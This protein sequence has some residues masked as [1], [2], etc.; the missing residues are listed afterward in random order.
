M[1]KVF[2]DEQ[3]R[4][5]DKKLD[6]RFVSNRKGGGN[7]TLKYLQGHDAID[8]ADRIFGYGNWGYRPLSCEQQVLIDPMTGEAV[9]VA[10]KAQVELTVRGCVA[11]IVE[12]GSQPVAVWS[13]E[14]HI[15]KARIS[16]AKYNK[17]PVDESEF[18]PFEK[19]KARGVIVEAHEMAEKGAVTD[20]LKRA[21]R[22]F[23]EQF[24]N[25]LYGDGRVMLDDVETGTQHQPSTHAPQTPA[26]GVI[27]EQQI[28]SIR[29]LCQ[30]L[31]K[32]E[33]ENL[34]SLKYLVAKAMIQQLTTEHKEMRQN[35]LSPQVPQYL[36]KEAVEVLKAE[37]VEVRS[38]ASEKINE[39]WREFKAY[40]NENVA[41]HDTQITPA[42]KQKMQAYIDQRRPQ[43]QAS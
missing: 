6:P 36:S 23:G 39:L 8:Q 34:T 30:H 14:D 29:K 43:Q 33:P 2:S 13:V 31:S 37:W 32:D 15:I 28:A 42:L 3:I 1:D 35:A 7:T 22:V 20:A 17:K 12:V 11:P 9:G 16:N 19:S 38:I 21:L 4:E 18:T 25:S 41:V 10:Y 24:G 40:M 27:T 26:D 5:L